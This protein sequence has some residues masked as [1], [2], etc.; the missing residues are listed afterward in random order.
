MTDYENRT[1]GYNFVLGKTL[2]N[3]YLPVIDNITFITYHLSVRNWDLFSLAR[4]AVG[5]NNLI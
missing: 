1:T 2:N 5:L 3:Y 4:G